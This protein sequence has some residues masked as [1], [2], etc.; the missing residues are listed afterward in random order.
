MRRKLK[1]GFNDLGF[2][3]IIAHCD[4]ENYGSYRVMEHIDMRREGLFIECRPMNKMS[5][6]KYCDVFSYAILAGE[7]NRK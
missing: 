6:K 5:G 2:R 3:R 7:W 4:A 1:F